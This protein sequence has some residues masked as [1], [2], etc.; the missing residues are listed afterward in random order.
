MTE[1]EIVVEDETEQETEQKASVEAL[2]RPQRASTGSW[3]V[4]SRAFVAKDS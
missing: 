2:Q 4:V 3:G 1:G